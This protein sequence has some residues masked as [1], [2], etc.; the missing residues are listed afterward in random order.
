MKGSSGIATGPASDNLQ[1]QTEETES[2]SFE[3]PRSPFPPVGYL[4]FTANHAISPTT[5]APQPG[6]NKGSGV[7]RI[8]LLLA[9][10]HADTA[11]TP[12][13]F[14]RV[15][16]YEV[17][18]ATSATSAIAA[19]ESEPFDLL[20]SDLGLPD[21][22]GYEVMRAVR[23]RGIVPGIAMSGYGM[24]DDIRRSREAGFTEHLVKPIAIVS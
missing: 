1:E 7:R 24:E 13:R 14:L 2:A 9:E 6:S 4:L 22:D 10:D 16:G 3:P 15:A 23:A 20:I 12:G 11:R 19:A 21:G 17:D 8:R 5:A 18:A